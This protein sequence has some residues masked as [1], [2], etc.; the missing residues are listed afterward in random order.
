[1][2][3]RNFSRY[4]EKYILNQKQKDRFVEQLLKYMLKDPYA[5]NGPY[6]IYSHY[7]DNQQHQ[8]IVTSISKPIY[9]EKVRVRSYKYPLDMEDSLFLEIKKKFQKRVYKKRIA[10]TYAQYVNYIE[11]QQQ[12]RFDNY[13][14]DQTFK[15]IDYV[16][17]TYQLKPSALI[18]YQREAL[19][20]DDNDLRITFDSNI[21]FH[22]H[23]DERLLAKGYY[24]VEIKTGQNMPLWLT[25][26]L[27]SQ[28]LLS[29]SFSKYGTAY[30][31][32]IHKEKLLNAY[33]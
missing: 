7:F 18:S 20:C 31:T 26:I 10:L 1:M 2:M 23:R 3:I 24:V 15:N 22:H 21:T 29:A 28:K 14:D 4:E 11:Y 19:Y 12:P 9:K 13:F 32:I 27:T 8:S 5:K 16:I 33:N 25:H 30:K 6:T 17:K